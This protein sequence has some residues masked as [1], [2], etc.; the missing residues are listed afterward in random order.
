[1]IALFASSGRQELLRLMVD[2]T[3]PQMLLS[4]SYTAGL[5]PRR[6][7]L[8]ACARQQR[9]VLLAS[10]ASY[11][12][13]EIG[14]RFPFPFTGHGMSGPENSLHPHCTLHF[15]IC[16]T[17][18]PILHDGIALREHNDLLCTC[19]VKDRFQLITLIVSC[20][21][22]IFNVRQI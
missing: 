3:R 20:V 15:D 13:W 2:P 9:D 8:G 11:S 18:P 14:S 10:F 16:Y 19:D 12:P 21:Q 17:S 7:Q 6:V 5:P 22:C 4:G 1:M